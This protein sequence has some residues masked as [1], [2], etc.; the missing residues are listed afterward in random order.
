M[1][2]PPD[3]PP[4]PSPP[5]ELGTGHVALLL[6]SGHL[7]GLVCP[8]DEPPHVVRGCA[9]KNTHV[10]DVQVSETD[11]QTK[12]VTTLSERIDLVIRAV[13]PDGVIHTLSQSGDPSDETPSN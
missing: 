7:D 2:A 10:T 12:T 5:L 11:G 8:P 1:L 13:G 6:A 9:L 4:L 3:D